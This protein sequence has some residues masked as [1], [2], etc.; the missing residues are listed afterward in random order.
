MM[1]SFK[2]V[3][4]KLEQLQVLVVTVVT[5]YALQLYLPPTRI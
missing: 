1:T 4:I 3:N 5:L 2:K